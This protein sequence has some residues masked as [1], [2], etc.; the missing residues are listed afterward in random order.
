[1]PE[2]LIAQ[3]YV[4]NAPLSI[5]VWDG[6]NWME[7]Q[8]TRASN[9]FLK[10]NGPKPYPAPSTGAGYVTTIRWVIEIPQ[11]SPDAANR[12]SFNVSL[13]LPGHDPVL[14][15]GVVNGQSMAYP[16][17][18]TDPT[19]AHYHVYYDRGLYIA[20][21]INASQPFYVNLMGS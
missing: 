16:S 5:G 12:I 1:M 8:S 18:L 2:V 15:P 20:T 9:D 6:M 19:T 14:H 4:N 10:G 11:G 17:A 21:P 3:I 13:D 7:N